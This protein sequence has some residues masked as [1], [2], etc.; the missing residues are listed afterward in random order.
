MRTNIMIDDELVTEAM[1]IAGARSKR[2]VV[3]LALRELVSR[4]RQRQIKRLKGNDLINP[5]YDVRAVRKAMTG[6]PG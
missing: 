3:D 2:E 1:R 6:N 5:D 4:Y